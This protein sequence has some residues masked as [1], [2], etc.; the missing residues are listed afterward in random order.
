MAK[1]K[2]KDGYTRIVN[3]ILENLVKSGLNGSELA[4]VLHIIRKTYG[5][6]KKQDEISISQFLKA[7]PIT[8]QTLCT[9]IKNL[10]LMN[11]IRL[12]RKGKHIFHS[13]LW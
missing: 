7:I 2:I 11:I 10:K 5:F 6:Q 1:P 12:V 3:P 4:I 13:N 8:R 9:S